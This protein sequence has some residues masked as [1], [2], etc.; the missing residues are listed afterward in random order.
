MKMM[1]MRKSVVAAM[2]L[3]GLVVAPVAASVSLA[4][5]PAP[6]AAAAGGQPGN[7]HNSVTAVRK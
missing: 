5:D 1:K 2:R 3:F 7:G 6:A 4:D